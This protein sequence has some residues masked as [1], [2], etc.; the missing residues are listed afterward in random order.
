MNQSKFV[1]YTN[2]AIS[3]M[4]SLIV[5]ILYFNDTTERTL[6]IVDNKLFIA[7]TGI[8]YLL[9]ENYLENATS[10]KIVSD[11]EYEFITEKLNR[12]Y[13]DLEV[14]SVYVFHYKLGQFYFIANTISSTDL[15]VNSDN[16]FYLEYLPTNLILGDAIRDNRTIYAHV[17]DKWGSFRSIAIPH[18]LSNGE[19]V[20]FCADVTQKELDADRW[21]KAA[22]AIVIFLFLFMLNYFTISTI[23]HIY[24]QKSFSSI[25]LKIYGNTLVA[26]FTILISSFIGFIFYQYINDSFYLKT[27]STLY[28]TSLTMD[29]ILPEDFHDRVEIMDK[30]E[31]QKYIDQL[32]KYAKEV[33]IQYLYTMVEKD[34]NFFFAISSTYEKDIEQGTVT[35]FMEPW[36][37]IE[38]KT[39][40][41]F[42]TGQVIYR[43]ETGLRWGDFRNIFIPIK[44]EFGRHY[45]LGS[46]LPLNDI[47]GANQKN[48]L[49]GVLFG[50]FFLVPVFCLV[51]SLM[52][53]IILAIENFRNNNFISLRLKLTFFISTVTILCISIVSY[54][55]LINGK[56]TIQDKTLEICRTLASNLGNIARE[57]L[58]LDTT[59]DSTNKTLVDI[60]K[61]N[62]EGIQS[63]YIINA[64]GKYVADLTKT[65]KGQLAPDSEISYIQKLKGIELREEFSIKNRKQFLKVTYP[66][67]IEY[68]S[69]TIRIGAVVFEYD[70][71]VLYKPVYEVQKIILLTGIFFLLLV[72]TITYF[73]S[74]FITNPL[75]YLTEGTKIIAKGNLNHVLEVRT[76]DEVGILSRRFNEMSSNLK[77][78]YD[79]LEEKVTQRTSELTKTQG[80]LTSVLETTPIILFATDKE[81]I[82]TLC[83]GKALIHIGI[84]RGQ[85]NGISIFD[86][87]EDK[88]NSV[89]AAKKAL[90]GKNTIIIESLERNT[91]EVNFNTLYDVED[92]IVGLVATFFDITESIKSQEAIKVEKEKSDSLLLNILPA[93]IA[94]ELKEK[95][96][97]KPVQYNSVSVLFTDFKGF[98]RLASTLSPDKLVEKLDAIFLQFDNMCERRNIE[99]LKTIG[100]AYMCVGGLPIENTTHP[101]D[102][103]LA[104]IEMQHFMKETKEIMEM[105]S[106]EEFL[107]MRLGIHTGSVVAGVIGK[108]KFAFDIW[109]DAVNIASRMESNGEVGAINI[110]GDTYELVKDFFDCE[111]RGKIDAKNRGLIEM[112]FLEKIKPELSIE[113]KGLVPNEQFMK[114]YATL[115]NKKDKNLFV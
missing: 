76:N 51:Y 49:K 39:K 42:Y 26:L 85:A 10:G 105:V 23:L 47:K 107:D 59:Y 69:K 15:V 93:K 20:I 52:K 25:S 88:P 78:S 79:S 38:P 16:P 45:A 22:I 94:T 61:N 113:G 81:G 17:E 73:L 24:H 67:F 54:I 27:D 114:R 2:I 34:G 40:E 65:K 115:S 55:Y 101:I 80:T 19:I 71:D 84:Q 32:S 97:V 70:K 18:T 62:F 29:S 99:K 46:D 103:C 7:A 4:I 33:N 102:I 109:G 41:A 31:H 66:I 91:F 77:K 37:Q 53:S 112:Y 89:E 9:P 11:S 104:A 68:K 90:L 56:K 87:F 58:L 44:K 12:Y 48:I 57:D 86:L 82:V 100:D 14:E 6:E 83:E 8:K 43:I 111:S 64:F 5:A 92:N 72:I 110:S 13:N 21:E 96:F 35:E 30:Q 50:L 108:A 3:V 1:R 60:G 98:T 106:G 63:V 74:K 28:L 95:G 36:P 75:L